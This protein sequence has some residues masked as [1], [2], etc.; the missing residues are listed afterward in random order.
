[1]T[2]RWFGTGEGDQPGFLLAIENPGDR[3]PFAGFP[4]QDG[5]EP[6]ID[7]A[8]PG[9]MDGREAGIERFHDPAVAPA[10]AVF[11]NIGLEQDARLQGQARGVGSLMDHRF[12]RLTLFGAQPDNVFSDFV[13]RHDPI[14]RNLPT[15]LPE[16][17]RSLLVSMTR[18]TS[19]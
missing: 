6:L 13:H 4:A 2:F 17:H 12:E 7:Q 8:L 9:P 18:A 1:M 5:V 14:P 3:R 10:V 11:G 16:S 15:T 19:G